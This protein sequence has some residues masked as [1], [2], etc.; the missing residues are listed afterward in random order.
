MWNIVSLFFLPLRLVLHL[1]LARRAATAD[2][3]VCACVRMHFDSI[4]FVAFICEYK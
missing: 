1:L 4:E 3:P 2:C